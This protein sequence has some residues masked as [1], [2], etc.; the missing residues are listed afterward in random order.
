MVVVVMVAVAI[1]GRW[2][3]NVVFDSRYKNN[4][5]YVYILYA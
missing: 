3:A 5:S 4:L 1:M 2:Q